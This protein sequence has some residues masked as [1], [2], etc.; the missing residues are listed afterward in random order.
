MSS[1]VFKDG[2][3]RKLV[4]PKVAT[5]SV[6]VISTCAA[7]GQLAC[8]VHFLGSGSWSERKKDWKGVKRL[9]SGDPHCKIGKVR[10]DAERLWVS[11][12]CPFTAPMG[13]KQNGTQSL[14]TWDLP[15][16]ICTNTYRYLDSNMSILEG[17]ASLQPVHWAFCWNSPAVSSAWHISWHKKVNSTACQC[18]NSFDKSGLD[19]PGRPGSYCTCCY[20]VSITALP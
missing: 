19:M 20:Q 13:K 6:K 18:A 17:I 1:R 12:T 8:A 15:L 14:R 9:R 3:A 5:V 10:G 4:K 16:Q 7:K 2:S 11:L